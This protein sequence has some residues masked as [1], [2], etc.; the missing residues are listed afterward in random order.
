MASFGH[1]WEQG[2]GSGGRADDKHAA[3]QQDRFTRTPLK[4]LSPH[5]SNAVSSYAAKTPD[6]VL[7]TYLY[8]FPSNATIFLV[9]LVFF[10]ICSLTAVRCRPCVGQ[11][12]SAVLSGQKE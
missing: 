9:A 6:Y 12:R 2:Q 11:T 4:S 3:L 5:Q 10:A 1:F 7:A 8:S